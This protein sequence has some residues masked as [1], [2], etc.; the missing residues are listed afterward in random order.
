MAQQLTANVV[1]WTAGHAGWSL[2]GWRVF[3]N[4][5][6]APLCSSV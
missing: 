5:C 3:R 6:V 4:R 2:C 1:P